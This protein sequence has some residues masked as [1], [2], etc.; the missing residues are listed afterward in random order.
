MASTKKLPQWVVTAKKD[1]LNTSF[2]FLF[3][4][5]AIVLTS[6]YFYLEE[7]NFWM[8]PLFFFFYF[9]TGLS[10]TAGYHRLFAH[11]GY[12]AHPIVQ[13]IY[14]FFGAGAFQNSAL[15]WCSDH[16]V[17]HMHVD[18][19]DDPYSV[20]HGFWHA[21]I[22]WVCKSGNKKDFSHLSRDLHE[23][24][25]IMWQ[26]NNIFIIGAI[27]GW[28]L[29]A[30]MGWALGS[31]LG[32]L[33]L[34]GMTRIV[35]VHH[36]TFFIN[37]L[38]HYWGKQTYTDRNTARDNGILALFTY[39]EGYHNFHHL[40]ANDYRNGIRWF[41]YDP[42]KWMIKTLSYFGFAK[43][44]R[45]TPQIHILRARMQ[46]KRKR[47]EARAMASAEMRQAVI[48]NFD[49]MKAKVE[50]AYVCW[51]E[52]KQQYQ[53]AYREL[54]KRK[55]AEGRRKLALMKSEL[56]VARLEWRMAYA[57]WNTHSTA[58]LKFAAA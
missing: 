19:D 32:G 11:K 47:L 6:F 37:S 15:K 9:A 29:P 42:T 33:A 4:I 27:S 12:E 35:L 17:H 20:N 57:Q 38:C 2:M 36:F 34:A 56:R 55:T 30:L 52:K 10:I 53:A 23:N 24:K 28:V 50:A 49:Q 45:V 58:L 51:S 46:M 41:H 26:H 43:G 16:R 3:P 21:H 54:K 13:F 8:I 1:W 25:L 22:G 18:K 5:A 48:A 44:L 14:L 31:W 7:F 39:G 40:F